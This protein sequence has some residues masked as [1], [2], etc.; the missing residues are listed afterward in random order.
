MPFPTSAEVVWRPSALPLIFVVKSTINPEFWAPFRKPLIKRQT[1]IKQEEDAVFFFPIFLLIEKHRQRN[2]SQR[3]VEG[4][5]EPG[6]T[7]YDRCT[8]QC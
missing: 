2:I 7:H 4:V 1:P 3:G 8:G 5:N 6:R